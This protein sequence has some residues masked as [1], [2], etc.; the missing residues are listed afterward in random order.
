VRALERNRA[1]LLAQHASHA[2][3]EDGRSFLGIAGRC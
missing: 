1:Q 3:T 2:L